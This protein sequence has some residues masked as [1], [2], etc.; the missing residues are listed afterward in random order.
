MRL[1]DCAISR[2]SVLVSI[3]LKRLRS[4]GETGESMSFDPTTFFGSKATGTTSSA[5]K[6]TL[7]YLSISVAAAFAMLKL[8]SPSLAIVAGVFA[9]VIVSIPIVLVAWQI[10]YFTMHDP[11]RLH[12]ERHL[13]TKLAI[14]AG[15]Y[16]SNV[17]RVSGYLTNETETRPGLLEDSE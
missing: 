11:D 10:W 9:G 1:T 4:C 12:N 13:E 14:K 3:R 2:H 5:I 6:P 7:I 16:G 15:I 8:S 17:D